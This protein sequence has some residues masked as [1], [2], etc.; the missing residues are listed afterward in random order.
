MNK[1]KCLLFVVILLVFV[2]VANAAPG[3]GLDAG[4]K[5]MVDA[6]NVFS[7]KFKPT[8]IT[9]FWTL[10]SIEFAWQFVFKYML[11]G[12]MEKAWKFGFIRLFTLSA[13]S[14]WVL[15]IKI[16]QEIFAWFINLGGNTSDLAPEAVFDKFFTI[17]APIIAQ[18]ET[19]HTWEYLTPTAMLMFVLLLLITIL[20]V[21][22]AVLVAYKLIRFAIV[23]NIGFLLCGFAGSSWTM[24]YWQKYLAYVVSAAVEFM[25]LVIILQFVSVD[26]QGFGGQ[27]TGNIMQNL[28]PLIKFALMIFLYATL[29]ITVPSMVS[30][31]FNGTI[32]GGLG[33]VLGVAGGA[34]GMAMGGVGL[35]RAVTG[36]AMNTG[37]MMQAAS[38]GVRGAINSPSISGA[39]GGGATTGWNAAK[40][41]IKSVSDK[42]KELNQTARENG[43]QTPSQRFSEA[44]QKSSSGVNN[45]SSASGSG[46]GGGGIGGINASDHGHV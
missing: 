11:P 21:I 5:T 26:A 14:I 25:V 22:I 4:T 29:I 24:S 12:D 27:F 37:K 36:G 33:E 2:G 41:G 30:G 7:S 6:A 45:V 46:S 31:L 34:V 17:T 38:S 40:T 10:A 16:Y 3:V 23:F 32:G 15:D 9:L 42:F 39:T 13:Y 1:F 19:F 44:L 28:G 18:L 43:K 8:V 35:A 20:A